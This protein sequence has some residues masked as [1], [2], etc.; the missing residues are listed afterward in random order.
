MAAL[1]L[2]LSCVEVNMRKIC[3]RSAFNYDADAVSTETGLACN[4]DESVVQQQ[5][6]ENVISI[7]LWRVLV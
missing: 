6:A 2:S 3:C 7:R 4:P 1:P 5:F